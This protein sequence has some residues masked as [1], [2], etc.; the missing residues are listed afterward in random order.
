MCLVKGLLS[1]LRLTGAEGE[2]IMRAEVEDK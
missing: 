1:R 2:L